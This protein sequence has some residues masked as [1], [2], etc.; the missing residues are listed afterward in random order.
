MAQQEIQEMIECQGVWEIVYKKDPSIETRIWHISNIDYS[1]KYPHCIIAF[2]H[3]LGDDVTFSFRKIK[4]AKRY[5]INFYD[6]ETAP[7]SGLYLFTCRGDNHLFVESY[8]LDKGERLYKYFENEY[9]HSDGW[10]DVIPL[11]YHFVEGDEIEYNW[12]ESDGMFHKDAYD[13]VYDDEIIH[14]SLGRIK[15]QIICYFKDKGRLKVFEYGEI[16]H[17]R[18]WEIREK[19]HIIE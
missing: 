12:N 11:A 8:H 4:S 15:N 3:E 1:D 16:A 19:M 18:Y 9:E 10:F 7:V 17:C 6:D 13:D 2:C 14:I 5:W